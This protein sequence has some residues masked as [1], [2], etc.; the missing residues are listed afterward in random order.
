VIVTAKHLT[1]Q[2]KTL[3][4]QQVQLIIQ[5][6]GFDTESFFTDVMRVITPKG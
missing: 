5:K 2:E 3:L 1:D 4:T 6:A